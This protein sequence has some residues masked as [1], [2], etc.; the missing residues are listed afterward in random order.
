MLKTCI[1]CKVEKPLDSF[2][3]RR[4]AEDGRRS[5]CKECRK[6]E[7]QKRLEKHYEK[8]NKDKREWYRK[9]KENKN[10]RNEK[11]INSGNKLCTSCSKDK[12]PTDYY[13]RSN[14]GLQNICKEC[15]AIKSKEYALVN[16]DKVRGW[17][18]IREQ[19]RRARV[20]E[21]PYGFS[22]SDWEACVKFFDNRCAY[23]G[24]NCDTLTQDHVVAVSKGGP[25]LKNNIIPSCFKCNTRKHNSDMLD[26]FTSQDFYCEERLKMIEE[27]L[28]IQQP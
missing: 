17:K 8:L 12:P 22:A 24:I 6:E 10:E 18:R 19:R 15:W 11:A 3:K 16:K 25:Y 14:G 5:D 23:C 27:Y 21:L 20:R 1:L 2:H 7:T 13:F 28:K 4:S 9:S 26:W